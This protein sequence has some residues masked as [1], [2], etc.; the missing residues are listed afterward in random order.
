MPVTK[1]SLQRVLRGSLYLCCFLALLLLAVIAALYATVT[2]ERVAARIEETV[3]NELGLSLSMSALPKVHHLPELVITIPSST[4]QKPGHD[5]WQVSFQQTDIRLSPWA[6]FAHSP[7]IRELRVD[8]LAVAMPASELLTRWNE[9]YL[10]STLGYDIESLVV[11]KSSV[12]LLSE[13]PALLSDLR[14]RMTN[15]SE[16][17][18]SG[19]LAGLFEQ[20]ALSGAF[21]LTSDLA[22]AN[23]LGNLSLTRPLFEFKGIRAGKEWEVRCET[24]SLTREAFRN[25][26][27]TAPDLRIRINHQTFQATAD[28]ATW[29]PGGWQAQKATLRTDLSLNGRTTTW[30]VT[31]TPAYDQSGFFHWPDLRITSAN[32]DAS[33]ELTGALSLQNDRMGRIVL[34][35]ILLGTPAKWEADI[36]PAFS[37]TVETLPRPR[38]AG[39]LQLG[40][41]DPELW[42]ALEASDLFAAFDFSGSVSVAG[43]QNETALSDLRAEATLLNGRLM[44]TEGTGKLYGGALR[45]EAEKRPNGAWRL[46]GDGTGADSGAFFAR[47]FGASPIT[48]LAEVSLRAAGHLRRPE[49]A[50]TVDIRVLVP[51]AALR[52]LDL[53]A[54][55]KLL[56]EERSDDLPSEIL[57]D[58]AVTPVH[59]LTFRLEGRPADLLV[60]NGHMEGDGWEA[61]FGGSLPTLRPQL[62][63]VFRFDARTSVPALPLPWQ[64]EQST[65]RHACGWHLSWAQ[66]ASS[67]RDALGENPWSLG[68]I[69]R[70]AERVWRNFRSEIENFEFSWPD[71]LEIE[72]KLKEW[73]PFFFKEEPKSAPPLGGAI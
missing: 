49:E 33:T 41:Q 60:T 50:P 12:T 29:Q 53:A 10:V 59:S 43:L 34:A 55:Y 54:A 35:G 39:T 40:A 72:K 4:L 20:G 5:D 45:F 51:D 25:W 61:D 69:E 11:E 26:R 32:A 21:Q 24:T 52:G 1:T 66:T 44:L 71:T 28:A 65:D 31:G 67:V 57:E 17:G 70:R 3:R 46:S 56:L 15:L 19:H 62:Q 2:P 36:T 42:R 23:G 18:A 37:E 64:L 63:G 30:A 6:V 14:L 13:T 68:S 47:F 27:L 8:R 48:G 22:W 9:P 58:D 7:K 73:L 16:T 38:F